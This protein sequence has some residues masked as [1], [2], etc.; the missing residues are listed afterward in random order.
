MVLRERYGH[1][2]PPD[3]STVDGLPAGW[4][5]KDFAL[6]AARHPLRGYLFLR[7]DGRDCRP[8]LWQ[9]VRPAAD[10][11]PGGRALCEDAA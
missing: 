2:A 1:R 3:G 11:T 4:S 5:R 10:W 6:V 8:G 7:L 9:Q